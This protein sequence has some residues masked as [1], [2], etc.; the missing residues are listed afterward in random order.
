MVGAEC[1]RLYIFVLDFVH[2]YC[3]NF[4]LFMNINIKLSVHS[5]HHK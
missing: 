3:K 4:S 1:S 5:V 2:F